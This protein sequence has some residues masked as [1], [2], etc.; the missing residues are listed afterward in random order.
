MNETL[1][2]IA[3]WQF[4]TLIVLICILVRLGGMHKTLKGERPKTSKDSTPWPTSVIA[5]GLGW[6]EWRS[7]PC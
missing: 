5:L 3:W 7:W 1:T 6:T 2:A 4:F